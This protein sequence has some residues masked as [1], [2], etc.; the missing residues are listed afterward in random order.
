MAG[1]AGRYKAAAGSDDW[2][3]ATRQAREETRKRRREQP[4]WVTAIDTTSSAAR[5]LIGGLVLLLEADEQNLH[6]VCNKYVKIVRLE[7]IIFLIVGGLYSVIALR[8][9]DHARATVYTK[10]RLTLQALVTEA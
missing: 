6:N 10:H 5:H 1:K 7:L 2:S 3:Q 9:N 8:E 4:P